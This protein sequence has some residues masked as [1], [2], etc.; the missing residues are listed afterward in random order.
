M[1]KQLIAILIILVSLSACG[2][3]PNEDLQLQETQVVKD[4][5]PTL[6]GEF[7]F[8]SDA[9]VLKG[10][11]FIYGV[12]ID[13]ISKNLAEQVEAYKTDQFEMVP[14]TIKAKIIPNPGSKG[15]DEFIE[16]REVLSI[17]VPQAEPADST[18]N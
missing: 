1:K 4:S 2:S 15:W 12:N 11:D 14:V 16:I 8:L 17:S 10:E 7:I 3:D 18:S 5:I 6:K 9:A 13:S